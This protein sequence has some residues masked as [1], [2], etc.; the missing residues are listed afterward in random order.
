MASKVLLVLLG[1]LMLIG[2]SGMGIQTVKPE[3]LVLDWKDFYPAVFESDCNQWVSMN[4]AQKQRLNSW[5]RLCY[6]TSPLLTSDQYNLI[7]DIYSFDDDQQYY[8]DRAYSDITK[9]E[10]PYEKS[11]FTNLAVKVEKMGMTVAE[12]RGYNAMVDLLEK[13]GLSTSSHGCSNDLQAVSDDAL[14]CPD[15]DKNVLFAIKYLFSPGKVVEARL[16][17]VLDNVSSVNQSSSEY[18]TAM[19][20]LNDKK[21]Q[22]LFE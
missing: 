10:K 18:K 15:P 21:L 13:R 6:Q 17:V 11:F 9:I 20:I 14:F 22:P 16:G 5:K 8:F 3:K 19:Q 7:V 1:V 12:E 2:C 4:T